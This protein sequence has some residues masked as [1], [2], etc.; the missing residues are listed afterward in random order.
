MAVR[1]LLVSTAILSLGIFTSSVEAQRFRAPEKKD[2]AALVIPKEYLPPAGLC[3]VWIEKV[4]A[5]QQPAPTD[6]V[7]AI[8][9]RPTNAK[10]I[11]GD[12]PRAGLKVLRTLV[13]SLKD[14]AEKG[15]AKRP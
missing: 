8:K 10:V 14:N 15:K 13:D 11:F 5:P 4:P 6:C 1:G 2:S 3:R 7:T 9:N 12:D